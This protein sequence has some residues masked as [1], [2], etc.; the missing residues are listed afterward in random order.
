MGRSGLGDL[1]LRRYEPVDESGVVDLLVGSLACPPHLAPGLWRWKHQ[2]NPFGTAPVWVATDRDRVVAVRPFLAWEFEQEGRLV[3]AVRAVDTATH[4][5]YRGR[6]LFRALTERALADLEAGG[7]AFV[8]NTPN[9]QSRPGYL[10]MG[11]KTVGRLPVRARFRSMASLAR[12]ARARV[13][14]DLE[15]ARSN[16]TVGVPAAGVVAD[17]ARFE[18]VLAGGRPRAGLATRRSPDFLGWRYGAA[19]LR[20][21]A[22]VPQDTPAAVFFRLRQRGAAVEATVCD[23]VAPA[24]GGR[25]IADLLRP[26]ARGGPADYA[27]RL[28]SDGV[29]R[30]RF[31][32]VPRQGPILVWRGVDGARM[33]A[34]QDWRL[35]LG[36][37][38]LF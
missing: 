26:L 8:F 29:G 15:S 17:P 25:T 4:P 31:V 18:A 33:P 27:V 7:V 5:D 11:W 13:P 3:R 1:E 37:V 24:G 32:P 34:L 28:A 22:L 14:A 16:D 23:V 20:Y 38:E 2:Q 12:V 19:P 9:D 36:D 21:R 10:R 6:G 30:H 35:C